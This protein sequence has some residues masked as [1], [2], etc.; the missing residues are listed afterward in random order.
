MLVRNAPPM[1]RASQLKI[2]RLGL[3]AFRKIGAFIKPTTRMIQVFG[4][5]AIRAG[6]EI[7]Q[8]QLLR[9]L[10]GGEIPVDSTLD[11]GYV[12]LTFGENQILGIGFLDNGKVRSQIPKK[13]LKQ[14]MVH[15]G[16]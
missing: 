16:T 8:E 14:V 15:V 1:R 9:L 2:S 12:I 6:F 7:N 4:H 10:E 11:K 13:E 5:A 3:K